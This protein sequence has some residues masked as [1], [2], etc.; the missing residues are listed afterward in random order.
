MAVPIM[1]ADDENRKER[2]RAEDFLRCPLRIPLDAGDYIWEGYN[3]FIVA[4]ERKKLQD[5]VECVL[6]TNRHID[7][8]TRMRI[9]YDYS[10]LF[11]EGRWR[12]GEDGL[13][14]TPRWE[15]REGKRRFVW[16]FLEP[17][18]N[19]D[20]LMRHLETVSIRM[21]VTI[22][23]TEDYKET[24][25]LIENL[26]EWWQKPV[27]DHNSVL[28]MPEPFTLLGRISLIVK[29]LS[30]LPGVGPKLALEIGKTYQ[31]PHEFGQATI[32]DLMK[33]P[34]IGRKKAEDMYKAWREA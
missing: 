7:Q 34:G 21:G 33:V 5:L 13:V 26:A 18:I 29:I 25:D 28:A 4:A 6:R 9:K 3:H 19:Y 12:R 30:R 27:E 17:A 20:R 24:C 23:R 1:V 11:I 14:E 15:M 8:L 31:T 22:K 16:T 10:Y 32:P 2:N